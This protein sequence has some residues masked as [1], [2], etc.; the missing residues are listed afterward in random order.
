MQTILFN[1][2]TESILILKR[3]KS[4]KRRAHELPGHLRFSSRSHFREIHSKATELV[5]SSAGQ[6]FFLT[7]VH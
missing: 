4:L 3:L 6:N 1:D 2:T 7:F 5:S